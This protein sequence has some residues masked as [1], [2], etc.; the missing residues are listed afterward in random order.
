LLPQGSARPRDNE[1]YQFKFISGAAQI[2]GDFDK[3]AADLLE[4]ESD[5][6]ITHILLSD[7]ERNFGLP[8]DCLDEPL[9]IGD[10]QIALVMRVTMQGGQSRAFFLA[11]AKTIKHDI[12]VVEHSPYQCGIS[13][14]GDTRNWNGEGSEW[15]RWELGA[16]TMRYYWTIQVRRRAHD[17]VSGWWW[18]RPMRCRSA[19]ALVDRE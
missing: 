5:P 12:L 8:D 10:R 14:V 16:E 15:F 4:I 9:T 19:P 6:R 1:S 11:L 3:L 2:W 13:S 17:L 7:W 18:R